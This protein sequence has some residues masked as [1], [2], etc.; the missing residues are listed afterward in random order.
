[1]DLIKDNLEV[2]CAEIGIKK[3]SEFSI[4][5]RAYILAEN[6]QWQKIMKFCEIVYTIFLRPYLKFRIF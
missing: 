4:R 5:N 2:N 1:M 3:N 6:S